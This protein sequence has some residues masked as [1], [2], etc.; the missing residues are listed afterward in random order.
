MSRILDIYVALLDE[1]V[2]VWRPVRAEQLSSNLYR[3][4]AQSYDRAV[5]SWQFEPGDVVVCE[6]IE[7]SEGHILA[8]TRKADER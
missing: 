5:E 3:I 4:L 8:A 7:S 6:T 2:D 1:G